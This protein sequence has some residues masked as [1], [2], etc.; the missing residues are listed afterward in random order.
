MR[1]LLLKY[2]PILFL[3]LWVSS[4]TN[5]PEQQK[6]VEEKK[7]EVPLTDSTIFANNVYGYKGDEGALGVYDVPEMLALSIIDSAATKDISSKLVKNYALL[8]SDMNEIGAEMNG[9]I[10]VINYNNSL[11]NFKFETILLIRKMPTK[12][13]PHCN[14]VILEASQMLVFNFYGSYQ[15]L[16]AAYDKI[17]R[18]S[19]KHDLLQSGPMREFYITDPEK[20]KDQSKWLTRIMVPVVSMRRK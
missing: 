16:F 6:K 7:T 11:K 5:E 19:E 4:C 14:V 3:A 15:N 1:F 13:P 2:S 8:E 20:E 18:Y 9:P 10:G 12:Q 17:K